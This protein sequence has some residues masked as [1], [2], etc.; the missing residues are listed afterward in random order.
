MHHFL[1]LAGR[2]P[3]LVNLDPAAED[4]SLPLA[5]EV[6][7]RDLVCLE[8]VMREH[9]L[10]PNGGLAYCISYLAANTDWLKEKLS[11]S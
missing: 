3:L 7:V 4:S 11:V 2:E 1:S 5:P 6:D 9:G 10:G 8:E